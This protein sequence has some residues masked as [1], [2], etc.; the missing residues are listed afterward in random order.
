MPKDE[1][2]ETQGLGFSMAENHVLSG[3]RAAGLAGLSHR[4]WGR[5]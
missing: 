3:G 1:N 2:L 5:R 4:P